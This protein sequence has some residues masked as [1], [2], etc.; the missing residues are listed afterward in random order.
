MK[1]TAS[2]IRNS[3]IWKLW[4]DAQRT[5]GMVEGVQFRWVPGNN[6]VSDTLA[7]FQVAVLQMNDNIRI[8][9]SEVMPVVAPIP[10]VNA[11]VVLPAAI[12]APAPSL[13]AAPASGLAVQ[14][15]ASS[16]DQDES[17]IEDVAEIIAKDEP[18]EQKLAEVQAAVVGRKNKMGLK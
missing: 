18:P 1:F 5:G 2:V 7:P 8:E 9:A 15:A 16:A 4:S 11:P 17:V 3:A 10:A 6:Y 13:A 12:P 14:V